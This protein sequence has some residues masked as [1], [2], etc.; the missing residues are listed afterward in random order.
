MNRKIKNRIILI[1]LFAALA[2]SILF[3]ITFGS[4]DLKI[5]DVY[6]IIFGKIFDEKV[7]IAYKNTP[8]LD[9]VWLI[10]V[11]RILLAA[12]VGIGLSSC[13]AVMQSVVKN[14]MADPYILGVSSGA[15]F[16][17][18]VAIML[19]IF[20]NF[21]ENY[22][23]ISAFLGAFFVSVLVLLV[24][25]IG[26]RSNTLKLI[27]SGVAI[28][29]A[30]SAISNF[31]VFIVNDSSKLK[32]VTYWTMGS[33]AGVKWGSLKILSLVILFGFLYFMAHYRILDIMLLGED[34]ALTLGVDLNKYRTRL[35]LII[36]LVIGFVVYSSGMIGF[37]GLIVPHI[38][39]IFVGTSH[40]YLLPAA[41]M[42]GAIVLIWSDVLCRILIPN[43]EIP[44]GILI[45]ILGSPVFVYF[46][47]K[48][49]FG[50]RQ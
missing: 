10:R 37:V 13:G 9:V 31:I 22:I 32:T 29:S 44:I 42:I 47:I 49:G 11:P 38:A 35:L 21:S 8:M 34:Q 50:E 26:G 5:E 46:L 20:K 39:R 25:N 40:K 17:A 4:V 3:A 30:I 2:F 16:G 15:Y 45:S 28:S 7:L 6:K 41:S 23:G 36:S 27:L 33:L 19:G 43:T 18:V 24:S 1:F 48:S 12:L 14:P